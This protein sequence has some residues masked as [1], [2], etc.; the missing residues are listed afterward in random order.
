MAADPCQI[1][2]TLVAFNLDVLKRINRKFAALR[3]LASL[4]EQLGDVSVLIPN[5]GRLIPVVNIDLA[6]YE[7]LVANCPYLNLPPA[8]TGD[9]N[10]LQA[11][12]TGAYANFFNKL[13]RHP[14]NRMGQLQDQLDNF[15]GQIQG[16]VNSAMTQ[17]LDFLRCLQTVCAAGKAA[18]GQL[19]AIKDADIAA[20]INKFADN[21]VSDAGQVMTEGMKIKY[22]QIQDTKDQ[23]VALGADVGKDYADAKAALGQ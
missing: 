5:I 1:V 14:W 19:N 22:Q 16:D 20:E 4:L 8:T 7:N 6:L 15:L 13:L 18:I 17:S 23:L 9:L 11:M 3:S 10:Q 21:F 2:D 12:V